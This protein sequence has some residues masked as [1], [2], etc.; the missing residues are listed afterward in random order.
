MS[1]IINNFGYPVIKL[2][3]RDA[4]VSW[5]NHRTRNVAGFLGIC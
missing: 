5:A 3:D 1:A 4:E 2:D